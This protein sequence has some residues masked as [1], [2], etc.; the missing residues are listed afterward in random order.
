[1]PLAYWYIIYAIRK[2]LFTYGGFNGSGVV[3]VLKPY[4]GFVCVGYICW[5]IYIGLCMLVY[6]CW[7]IYI[8]L[9]VLVYM[10]WFICVDL[11]VLIYIC[12]NCVYANLIYCGYMWVR[13]M[14]I[15]LYVYRTIYIVLLYD[16]LVYILPVCVELISI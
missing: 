8:G 5:F 15:A 9:Y 7:F 10:Y 16:V 3:Y 14:H 6:I 11:Y 13:L 4:I 1:M 2:M 12:W